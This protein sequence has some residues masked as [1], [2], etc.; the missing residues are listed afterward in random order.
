MFDARIRPIIDPPLNRLGARVAQA[1]IGA[2]AVTLAGLGLGL[3]AAVCIAVEAYLIA[4][5]PLLASRLAD[6]LDGAVA[7]ASRKTDF[8]GYLDIVADFAFYGAIPLAFAVADPAT[9]A[10]AA[11]FLLASFYVNG[12]SFLG[13]AI[14]AEKHGIETDAQGE[15]SLFYSNGLLE[16][17]ETIGF[18]VLICLLPMYFAPLAWIFGALCLATAVLRLRTAH[19][20]FHS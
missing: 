2:N 20:L 6:G 18:F 12:T 4:L 15:K 7:R 9:N 16:G 3:L 1:G 5:L 17:F 10:I 8:G 11:A 19:H 14:L 13:F